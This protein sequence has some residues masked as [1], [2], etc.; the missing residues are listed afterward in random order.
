[1][2]HPKARVEYPEDL[3]ARVEDARKMRMAEDMNALT[4]V[5][6]GTQSAHVDPQRVLCVSF[7]DFKCKLAI[8]RKRFL[9]NQKVKGELS[10]TTC[11]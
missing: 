7:P 4:A 5:D 9:M 2:S 1:M 8:L 3:R 6:S 10:P 11:W